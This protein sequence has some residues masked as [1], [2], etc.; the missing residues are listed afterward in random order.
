MIAQLLEIRREE[1]NVQNLRPTIV[2][3]GA[4]LEADHLAGL[5]QVGIARVLLENRLVDEGAR[6]ALLG[7]D[8]PVVEAP[9]RRDGPLLGLHGSISAL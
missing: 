8:H 2:E 9:V 5:D 7:R 3:G 6:A 4:L 1:E